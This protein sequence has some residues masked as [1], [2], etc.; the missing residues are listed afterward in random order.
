MIIPSI[1]WRNKGEFLSF[2]YHW[3][4][5]CLLQNLYKSSLGFVSNRRYF[6]S[7]FWLITSP[8]SGIFLPKWS[9]WWYHEDPSN[10]RTL[11]ENCPPNI[12][13][14]SSTSFKLYSIPFILICWGMAMA[15]VIG[16][17][18]YQIPDI[19]LQEIR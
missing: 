4:M 12:L 19:W 1:W 9:N 17:D 8:K 3:L 14:Q 16:R 2:Q 7:E 5:F 6:T 18:L 15:G 11:S 13:Y 10:K